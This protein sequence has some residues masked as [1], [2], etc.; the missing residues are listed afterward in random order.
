MKTWYT[1]G[2]AIVAAG[3]MSLSDVYFNSKHNF[4]E[5]VYPFFLPSETR[6]PHKCNFPLEI[7]LVQDATNGFQ[8]DIVE[9]TEQQLDLMITGLQLTHPGSYFG[10]FSFK[11]KPIDPHG[12]A[13]DYCFQLDSM[14]S[15]DLHKIH[16]AYQQL[17]IGGGGDAAEAQLAALLAAASS[18]APG[19]GI[20]PLATR[21]IVLITDSEPHFQGDNEN[22]NQ[23]PAYTTSEKESLSGEILRN[24]C[25]SYYY[26]TVEQVINA[27]H[28]RN[29]YVAFFIFDE[30]IDSRSPH[31]DWQWMN[32]QLGQHSHFFQP[33]R[34]DSSNFW[35]SLNRVVFSIERIECMA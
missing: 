14:L 2:A 11:D 27:V 12:S 28:A 21:L 31:R 35:K 25:H 30:G 18:E 16:R 26:P 15:Q 24:S 32:Q 10:L 9:M 3:R 5:E 29:S 22:V 19:W 17:H 8:D 1:P 23:L 20:D 6:L 4:T 34:S 33:L 13:N 7:L